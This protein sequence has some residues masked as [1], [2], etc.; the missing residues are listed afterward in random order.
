MGAHI[1]WNPLLA[2][3]HGKGMAGSKSDSFAPSPALSAEDFCILEITGFRAAR[4]REP[5]DMLG[6]TPTT[7]RP[8]ASSD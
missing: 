6:L 2:Q 5:D 3:S 8:L 1:L 4:P 7:A